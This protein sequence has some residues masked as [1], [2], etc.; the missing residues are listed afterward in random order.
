MTLLG[1]IIDQLCGCLDGESAKR[2]VELR[3]APEIQA[4]VDVLADRSNE[5]LLTEEERAE[6]RAFIDTADF[7]SLFKLKARRLLAAGELS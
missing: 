2:V 3:I 7:I 1:K 4:R 5:G 6:Y